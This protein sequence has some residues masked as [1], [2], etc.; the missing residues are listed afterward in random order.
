MTRSRKKSPYVPWCKAPSDRPSKSF[1]HRSERLQVKLALATSEEPP[2]RK[3]FGDPW[4]GE[5]DGK[6]RL[7]DRAEFWML[8]K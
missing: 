7:R 2:H 5:K 1:A 3:S 4:N 8:R 6:M